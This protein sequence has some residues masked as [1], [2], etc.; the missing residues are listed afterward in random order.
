M[1]KPRS[2]RRGSSVTEVILMSGIMFLMLAALVTLSINIGRQWASGSSK[3][4]SDGSASLALQTVAQEIRDG[5]RASV[6]GGTLTVVMP[7][8]NAQGDY[9]RYTDG[10]SVQYYL[11]GGKLYRQRG[12]ATPSVVSTRVTAVAFTVNGEQVTLQMTA[13]R[14]SGTKTSTSTYRTQVTLRNLPATS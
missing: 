14:T 8:V 13:K 4:M 1:M 3:M 2:M 6:S 7:Y 11:S 5:I 12:S 10:T 9:D